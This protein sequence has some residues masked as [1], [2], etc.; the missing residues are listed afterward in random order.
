MCIG[1]LAATTAPV[2]PIL[3]CAHRGT[4]AGWGWWWL[5]TCTTATSQPGERD[6][7]SQGGRGALCQPPSL[8]CWV[9]VLMFSFNLIYSFSSPVPTRLWTDLP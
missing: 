4:V 3:L 1:V 6:T 5:P 2:T 7:P 9:L 8:W